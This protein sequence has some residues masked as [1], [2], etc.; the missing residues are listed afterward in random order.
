M[1]SPLPELW[2]EWLRLSSGMEWLRLSSDNRPQG[3][4]W[5]RLS[6]WIEWLRLSSTKFLSK[7]GSGHHCEV[8]A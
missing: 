5:L 4:E 2:I 6:S 8:R 1:T 3:M 7:A